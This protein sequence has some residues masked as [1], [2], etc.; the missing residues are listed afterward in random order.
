MCTSRFLKPGDGFLISN[1]QAAM[2]AGR[3]C[4]FPCPFRCIQRSHCR[5]FYHES[6]RGRC[7][8]V[9]FVDMLLPRRLDEGD[10]WRQFVVEHDVNDMLFPMY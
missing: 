10:Q 3:A 1:V 2:A 7:V 5:S 8:F 6:P 4:S 9:L